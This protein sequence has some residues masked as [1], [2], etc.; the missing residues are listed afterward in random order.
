MSCT[1]RMM[2]GHVVDGTVVDPSVDTVTSST[3]NMIMSRST[4]AEKSKD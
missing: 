4:I 3:E 2:T 1:C